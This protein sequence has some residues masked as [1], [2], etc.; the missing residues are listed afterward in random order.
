MCT[1]GKRIT[2]KRKQADMHFA[3]EDGDDIIEL[4][5]LTIPSNRSIAPSSRPNVHKHND[6]SAPDYSRGWSGDNNYAAYTR[7]DDDVD[8]D[9]YVRVLPC[10]PGEPFANHGHHLESE[11]HDETTD[12]PVCCSDCSCKSGHTLWLHDAARTA[13]EEMERRRVR[14]ICRPAA[15]GEGA[16]SPT[17]L[18]KAVPHMRCYHGATPF[19]ATA[20]DELLRHYLLASHHDVSPLLLR[21]QL[22]AANTSS[23]LLLGW[24]ENPYSS[25]QTLRPPT[26]FVRTRD[27]GDGAGVAG[28]MPKKHRWEGCEIPWQNRC[29]TSANEAVGDSARMEIPPSKLHISEAFQRRVRCSQWSA[30]SKMPG[31]PLCSFARTGSPLR[32]Q[33]PHEDHISF[34]SPL[35]RDGCE[36]L[37]TKRAR[38]A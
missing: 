20:T 13:L 16:A 35:P 29:D 37:R 30:A 27:D 9:P 18:A 8:D 2:S 1:Q 15:T 34:S 5:R 38:C 28:R 10:C 33:P 6:C 19:D 21:P 32:R 7:S 24:H 22:H 31:S 17:H 26:S 4:P 12:G 23:P 14:D 11:C 36:A 3:E 25:N